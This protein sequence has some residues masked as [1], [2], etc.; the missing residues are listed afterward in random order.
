[1]WEL[2]PSNTQN[3][4]PPNRHDP[5]QTIKNAPK[6]LFFESDVS[7]LQA[8][9]IARMRKDEKVDLS[10]LNPKTNMKMLH[11]RQTLSLLRPLG[12]AIALTAFAAQ[13]ASAGTTW[14]AGGGN[15]NIDTAANW[16]SDSSPDLTSGT[17]T[18]TFGTGGST[19]T[20]NTA[21]N[22]AGI[23]INRDANFTIANGAGDLTIGT[24][25][26]TVTPGSTTARTHSISESVTLNGTQTWSVSNT[27]I[28]TGNMQLTVSGNITGNFGIIKAGTGGVLLLSGTN[29]FTGGVVVRD[30]FLNLAN[31]AALGSGALTLGDNTGTASTSSLTL[32]LDTVSGT[33]GNDITFVRNGQSQT[34][35]IQS[36]VSNA[37][38]NGTITLAQDARFTASA[39]NTLTINGKITGSTGTFVTL[40]SS[41]G[42]VVLA[43]ATN[44][45]NNGV[46]SNLFADRGTLL[47]RGNDSAGVGGAAGVLGAGTGQ[48]SVGSN[49]VNGDN[50]QVLIDG[51]YT[52]ARAINMNQGAASNTSTLGGN[53]A[54]TSTFSGTV[55]L[56]SG[57]NA[58][59]RFTA[60]TNGTVNFTGNITGTATNGLSKIGNG[61][62]V[63]GGTG[64]STYTGT[65]TISTGA[66][67]AAKA[68]ALGSTADGTAVSD[69]A[70]LQL[71]GGIAIGAEALSLTGS[72]ISSGGAMRN[73][74]G[75]NSYA[76]VITL[77]GATRINSDANTLTLGAGGI[78]GTQDLTFGGSGNTIVSGNITTSTGTVTKDGGGT[79]TLS[80]ISTY[81]GNTTISSGTL[82]L[83][84]GGAGTPA[85]SSSSAIINNGTLAFNA[86]T[87][88]VTYA[89]TIS[90]NGS[91]VHNQSPATRRVSLTSTS[92][93]YS[94]GTF[95]SNNNLL[96]VNADTNLGATSGAL[97]LG[98]G[99]T[100]GIL[101]IDTTGFNSA[102]R[103]I[104]LAGNGTGPNANFLAL[105]VANGN[106]T[107]GGTISGSGALTMA[108]STQTFAPGG[109]GNLTFTLSGSNTY[110]G[111]TT[112]ENGVSVRAGSSTAL[113]NN[114]AVTLTGDG[115]RTTALDL[116]ANNLSIG[117]LAGSTSTSGNVI[118]GN[119]TLT[120]GANNASTT[121][122]GVISGS[123]GGLTKS[124]SGTLT[125]SGNNTYTG[126][127]TIS[128][129]TLLLSSSGSLANSSV[130][131]N[132]A[133][134]DISAVSGFT[135]A[136]GQS[137]T[138][139]G[140]VIGAVSIG[141]GTLAIGNSPGT[142]T[143]DNNLTLT[144]NSISNFE[145]N[146]WTAGSYDLALG[147]GNS[148]AVTFGGTLNVNFGGSFN[149]LG[150][151]K[152]FDFE[153]YSSSFGT[154]NFSGLA[155]GYTASFNDATG[156]LTV[157]PEPTTWALLAFSLTTVM[158]LRRRRRE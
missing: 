115:T 5:V 62:V 146:A 111:P 91:V 109:T 25:G 46:S 21:V 86:Q 52:I 138:G 9:G 12:C 149:T 29:S 58:T 80:G 70:A 130:I 68:T 44:D 89:N 7:F 142:M 95:V 15:T 57:S 117:S 76:G 43:N 156:M 128:A 158:V 116:N 2:G 75:N 140:T 113:G 13:S 106:A 104:V 48:L 118:L 69:G 145:V 53:T 152:I 34:K 105:N 88:N 139:N 49:N 19:A 102:T 77:A 131:N 133:T 45:F 47:L 143:F 65:T 63:L 107:F 59:Y 114:S 123:G 64:S 81:T 93:S 32:N 51:A 155:L 129:G 26:I 55:N 82:V 101:R 110:T 8:G 74:S 39:G 27:G 23:N 18:V 135:L 50:A 121:Y 124:G 87:F 72:G 20:I 148:Q 119:R 98:S 14:D 94:G 31:T 79:L 120:T 54:D 16:D 73:L 126:T 127:T 71:S 125:L 6:C 108:G 137:L 100:G 33:Y 132:N 97:N 60:A 10:N 24:G 42:T 103:A 67:T 38:L 56:A 150:S 1:M 96:A 85:I 92:N 84:S 83:S 147:R 134:L 4:T 66:L 11:S 35:T 37:T 144:L 151:V 157:V 28:G 17:S 3:G 122:A 36:R 141:S 40:L 90:G 136:T 41:N 61:T 154:K 22:F 30:G 153:S 112:I 99:S 78:T